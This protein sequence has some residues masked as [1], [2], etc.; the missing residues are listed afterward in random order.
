MAAAS[1]PELDM[2]EP[3][4]RHGNSCRYNN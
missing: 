4:I 2:C 1:A 3:L